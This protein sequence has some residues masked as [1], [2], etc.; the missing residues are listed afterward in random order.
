MQ[1]TYKKPEQAKAPKEKSRVF[2]WLWNILGG[3]ILLNKNAKKIYWYLLF[4]LF[5]FVL[6]I[7][8]NKRI[9]AKKDKIDQYRTEYR[10]AI[11]ELKKNNQFIPYQEN[12]E[13][14]QIVKERGFVKSD[15]NCYKIVVKEDT[16]D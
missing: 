14:L 4:L 15:K 5:F 7:L 11:S 13:L 1:T 16:K 10:E 12:Q 2:T 8:N 9:Q 3:E 6:M